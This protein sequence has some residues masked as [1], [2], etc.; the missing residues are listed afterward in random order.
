M[1]EDTYW[2]Q[3]NKYST[4][5]SEFKRILHYVTLG[6]AQFYA[7]CACLFAAIKHPSRSRVSCGTLVFKRTNHGFPKSKC[8]S[9][10][11]N[12][13]A[14][15]LVCGYSDN[16]RQAASRLFGLSSSSSSASPA[17]WSFS[18]NS[19]RSCSWSLRVSSTVALSISLVAKLASWFKAFS[20]VVDLTVQCCAQLLWGY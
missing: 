2:R 6:F 9:I 17:I 16:I 14:I 1:K 7:A 4:A 15:R 20:A 19:R 10:V 3:Y 8:Q 13:L 12:G 5:I 18:S 11:L